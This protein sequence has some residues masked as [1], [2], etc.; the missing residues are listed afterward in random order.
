MGGGGDTIY[1]VLILPRP[2]LTVT[3]T[4]LRVSGREGK[5]GGAGVAGGW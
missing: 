4:S 2:H 1:S 3:N 5:W